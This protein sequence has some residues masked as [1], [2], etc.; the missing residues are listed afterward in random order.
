MGN[1]EWVGIG[2]SAGTAS[3]GARIETNRIGL[4]VLT[5]TATGPLTILS[6]PTDALP[7]VRFYRVEA[8][9]P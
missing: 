9:R 4:A 8:A 2:E 1:K 3:A 6:D 5:A 7:P